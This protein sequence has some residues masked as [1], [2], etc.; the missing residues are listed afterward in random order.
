MNGNDH[1]REQGC[2]FIIGTEPKTCSSGILSSW[3]NI[4]L[5]TG[6]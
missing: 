5:N 2:A 3:L 6:V 1:D 4:L